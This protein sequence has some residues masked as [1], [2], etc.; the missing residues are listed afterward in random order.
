MLVDIYVSIHLF[1]RYNVIK[2]IDHDS[3]NLRIREFGVNIFYKIFVE[4]EDLV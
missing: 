1:N 3:V 2:Y 4:V